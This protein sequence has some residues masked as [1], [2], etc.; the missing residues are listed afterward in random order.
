MVAGPL[1]E[2]D[3]ALMAAYQDSFVQE[4][5]E[6]GYLERFARA[7]VSGESDEIV[8]MTFTPVE[9]FVQTPGPGAGQRL[10]RGA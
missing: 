9:A 8:G 6:L 3:R 7:V 10:G 5:R 4:L 2:G 1:E